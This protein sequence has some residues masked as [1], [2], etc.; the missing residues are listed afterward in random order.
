[1]SA[2]QHRERQRE[3]VETLEDC[4]RQ[5]DGEIASLKQQV[6]ANAS[7][8]TSEV[9]FVGRLSPLFLPWAFLGNGRVS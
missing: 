8:Q 7:D 5:R 1:M 6:S 4:V 2:Q 3:R 9:A